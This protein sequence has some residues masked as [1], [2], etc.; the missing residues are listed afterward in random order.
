MPCICNPERSS[1]REAWRVGIR[2]RSGAGCKCLGAARGAARVP[3]A[4]RESRAAPRSDAVDPRSLLH[5]AQHA[6]KT[7]LVAARDCAARPGPQVRSAP[8][9]SGREASRKP[10]GASLLRHRALLG[11]GDHRRPAHLA[12]SL[13]KPP[14]T[15]PFACANA[16][17][18][19]RSARPRLP[20]LE[21]GGGG[22]GGGGGSDACGGP[23]QLAVDGRTAE[24]RKL[25]A[26][27][28]R[29]HGQSRV[30][31]RRAPRRAQPSPSRRAAAGGSARR[32]LR[33]PSRPQLASSHA[34]R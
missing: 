13:V 18:D 23:P 17:D 8:S 24:G 32:G 9:S 4:V 29:P 10:F 20:Q 26:E 7:Q 2:L 14:F 15:N 31:Q 33:R 16:Q 12:G 22:G 5:F 6:L 30:A 34:E 11:G 25:Q 19:I 21:R 28:Q 3:L 27:E 1:R